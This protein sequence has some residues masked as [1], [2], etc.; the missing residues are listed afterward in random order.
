MSKT[1]DKSALG[2]MR[3][4][5]NVTKNYHKNIEKKFQEKF[6]NHTTNYWLKKLKKNTTKSG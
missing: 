3:N 6:D 1:E 2:G 5:P 4:H